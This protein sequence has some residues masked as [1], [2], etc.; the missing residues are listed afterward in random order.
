MSNYYN[1]IGKNE[2]VQ[3]EIRCF[4]LN[5]RFSFITVY[6]AMNLNKTQD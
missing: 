1:L 5:H 6:E 3:I 4:N 2:T